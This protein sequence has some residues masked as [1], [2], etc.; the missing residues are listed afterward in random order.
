MN[1]SLEMWLE[2]VE[3]A[4]PWR[5]ISLYSVLFTGDPH[6]KWR[7][8]CE[9][10]VVPLAMDTFSAPISGEA[11]AASPERSKAQGTCGSGNV[12]TRP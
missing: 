1:S 9:S 2:V 8:F 5:L 12:T 7:F 11:E 6:E 4:L 3:L 10:R